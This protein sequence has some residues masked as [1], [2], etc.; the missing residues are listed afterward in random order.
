M[1][2]TTA[3]AVLAILQ[4]PT[5]PPRA[6][7]DA[8]NPDEYFEYYGRYV[9]RAPSGDFMDVL[10]RQAEQMVQT[11]GALTPA[12]G[13]FAY[14]PGKWSVAEVL[15]H[16]ADT[17]R[18]FAFRATH[19]A[20]GDQNELPGMEQDDWMRGA[21]FTGRSHDDVLREWLVVRAATIAM[22]TALPA[23]APTRTGT[24]SGRKFSVRALLHIIPGHTE[25][26]LALHAERYVGSKNWPK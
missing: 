9:S 8:P 11:F 4:G 23:D 22:V 19:M 12:Q 18:I 2:T 20:R 10:R 14:E 17:E 25:Y 26:H 3:N 24:A 21:G 13:Q 1:D 15:G 7:I 5:T 6:R 16:M